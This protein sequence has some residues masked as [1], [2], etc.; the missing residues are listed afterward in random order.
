MVPARIV[1]GLFFVSLLGMIAGAQ[2]TVYFDGRLT[3]TGACPAVTAIKRAENPGKVHLEPGLIYQ[4]L[5]KNKDNATHLLVR[6]QGAKPDSRW[7]AVSCG[8]LNAKQRPSAAKQ[9]PGQG[10]GQVPSGQFLLA[11]S[12]LPAFCEIR[13]R[14]PECRDQTA[15]RP[16]ASRFSLHGLWPQPS[17]RSYCGV[18]S[19]DRERSKTGGW[20]KLPQLELSA[21]T[22]EGLDSLMPGTRSYLHRHEWT[23][24]GTCYGA[25]PDTYFRDS[26]ALLEQLNNSKVTEL[27]SQSIGRHLSST[28]VRR[29][30]DVAFGKG[31]G[32]RVRLA[33][34]D[35][36]ISELRISLKG[37]IRDGVSLKQLIQ[38]APTK[39]VG[40]RGGRVDKAGLQGR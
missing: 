32:Q 35:G 20:S 21:A 37:K 8:T 12:W 28:E 15:R 3:A 26:V 17:S 10:P 9:G 29:A 7:V 1:A 4:V 13:Q 25:P 16:D 31:A 11:A 23:K 18:S 33:C 39:S 6:I 14:R 19:G 24:H 27:F 5:G 22:R 36:M 38:A 2:A 30:F 34:K 40:C